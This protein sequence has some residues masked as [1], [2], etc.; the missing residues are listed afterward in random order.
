M[1]NPSDSDILKEQIGEGLDDFRR[2]FRLTC[3]DLGISESQNAVEQVVTLAVSNKSRISL[4]TTRF[5]LI[6]TGARV[7]VVRLIVALQGLP[8]AWDLPSENATGVL[9]DDIIR[10][11]PRV[12]L[13][14]FDV[15]KTVILCER[16]VRDAPSTE[17]WSAVYDLITES[18]V[19]TPSTVFN[20]SSL[21]T[22][23]RSTSS[24]Q[25]GK[26]QIHDDIDHR[27]LQEV[28]GCVYNDTGCFFD[29]YFG[30]KA[31]S[32]VVEQVVRDVDLQIIDNRWVDYPD[33]PSQDAFLAW[34]WGLQSA[35]FPRGPG[36]Y[37]SSPTLSLS[38]SDCK[39]KPDLFLALSGTTKHDAR[40]SWADVRV[41]GELKQ[42]ENPNDYKKEFLWLCG[43]AREVFTSQP[44]RLFLHGFVIR[45]SVIELWVFDRSGPYSCEKF[46]L[47][48]NPDR[49][50]KV[51]AGYTMMSDEE[52]GLNTYIKQDEHGKYIIFKGQDKD[53]E[54]LYLEDEPIAFQRAIV[55]RGTTCYRVKRLGVKDWE[56]VVKF[57]WRSD[58]RRAEG[59]LLQ[60]AKDKGV[61][62]I[63][64]LFGYQDLNSVA[65]LRRGLQFGKPRTFRL[66]SS[67]LFSQ[68]QSRTK[69]GHPKK[70]RSRSA[71]LDIGEATLDSSS[72]RQKR[73]RNDGAA[74]VARLHHS[75]RSRSG[76]SRKQTN[77]T[78]CIDVEQD[79][80]AK[81]IGKCSAE[82]AGATSL[83]ISRDAND[84]SFDNRIF[85]CLVVYPPG[86]AIDEFRSVKEFLEAL[87]DAIKGH[88]SLYQ[89]GEILHRD[90][91]KNNIII[92]D[93]ESKSDP[94]GL[95]ID[96]DLA[97]ELGSG[98]SGAR[99]RTG[100]ME[101]MAI[102]VL[103]GKTH[104]YRHDLE[105]FFYV[106]LWVI[107]RHGQKTDQNASKKSR[108]RDWYTGTYDQIAR[109]KKGD[110]ERVEFK[111]LIAE[112]PSEFESIKWMAEELRCLL[113]PM[114]D[115]TLFTGA[116]SD[117]ERIDSVYD[118][119]ISI[120]NK[121]VDTTS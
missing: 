34:F 59:E 23:F 85:C 84:E 57:S 46:D 80:N 103:K 6:S 99:H 68:T 47:H 117:P 119:M 9:V 62:G 2:L 77:I 13:G 51:M 102:E 94:R 105:S 69:S 56:F 101:F 112:F 52:L 92:T 18:K 71:G 55:C 31:W 39:R 83:M 78:S 20:S 91:S 73:E 58:K 37:Y 109:N 38:G 114:Q 89:H 116:Y 54:K 118:G 8:A 21:D 121:A 22:P 42:S 48:M 106:F 19:T 70:S 87:R 40:Y 63:A 61:W 75:K 60:L 113:F 49:F 4:F 95:L 93:T 79:G 53:E 32:S 14:K 30:G 74:E 28:N 81:S 120:F 25:Q 50:I 100:T 82:E 27:I 45:G 96:L 43:H 98:P 26:E 10:L 36:A 24:S 104:T 115:G 76:S 41:I 86:R 3:A 72:S 107:I 35:F 66:A 5:L 67:G 88:R 64:Q 17:I 44:T 15:P 1:T 33:P 11:A 16:V 110:M 111:E 65:N 97:K 7:I 12:I 90:V 108:L 29:E